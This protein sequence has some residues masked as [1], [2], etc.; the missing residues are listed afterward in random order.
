MMML[1]HKGKINFATA[2]QAHIMN[3]IVLARQVSGI[4]WD[5]SPE[6]M[7][8]VAN[9]MLGAPANNAIYEIY[10]SQPPGAPAPSLDQYAQKIKK[11][12]ETMN[13]PVFLLTSSGGHWVVVHQVLSGKFK[14]LSPTSLGYDRGDT[15]PHDSTVCSECGAGVTT[16]YTLA[17]LGNIFTP[18]SSADPTYR[19]QRIMLI[20]RRPVP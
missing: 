16:S 8:K 7:V 18:V 15:V 14:T 10:P 1:E 13:A 3:S 20:P 4:A 5:S 9:D 11:C 17:G 2:F 6:A 19:N 12:I